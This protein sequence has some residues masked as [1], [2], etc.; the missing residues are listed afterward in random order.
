MKV[1]VVPYN[2][3]WPVE[4]TVEA[5][6]IRS[7]VASV[8]VAVHHIGSTAIPGIFAKPVIDVLM[9]VNDVMAL[10]RHT[11]ALTDLGY[12]AMGEFGITGRRYFRKDSA[13]GVR[14]HQIHAFEAGSPAIERHLAFRNYMI[15][16]PAI[17]RSYSLLKRQLAASH[18]NDIEAYMDGKDSFIKEH[19]TKAIPCKRKVQ[20]NHD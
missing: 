12:E 17:A 19:E 2:P 14:T 5:N 4:F 16:H 3:G 8:I 11:S 9:E 6:R 1:L 13:G 18:P 7:A 15:A 20:P 10:D